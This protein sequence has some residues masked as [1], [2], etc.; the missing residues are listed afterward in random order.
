MTTD[1]PKRTSN[2]NVS[3]SEYQLILSLRDRNPSQNV[4]IPTSTKGDRLAD[5]ISAIVGSWRFVAIQS[6]LLILWIILNLTAF[7]QHW[8]PYPF[9]L[10]NLALSFQAAYTAPIIM[11]SQNRQSIIDRQTANHDYEIDLKAELEIELLHDT[12]AL[13]K[14]EEIRDILSLLRSQQTQIQALT[15]TIDRVALDRH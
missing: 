5:K 14:Q 7:I 8:D 15:D 11:M 1:R 10:L 12:I 9:I 13:L 6:S 4:P 2:L 3:E